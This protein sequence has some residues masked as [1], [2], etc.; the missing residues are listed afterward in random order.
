VSPESPVDTDLLRR[1]RSEYLEMP[2]LHLTAPQ[3]QRLWGLDRDTCQ[4]LF[5]ALM[6]SRFLCQARNGAF[7]LASAA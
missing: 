2:G 5:D 6:A 1:V 7:R 4:R 3:A